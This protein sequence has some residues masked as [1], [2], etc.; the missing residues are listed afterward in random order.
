[1]HYSYISFS[2]FALFQVEDEDELEVHEMRKLFPDYAARFH[3]KEDSDDDEMVVE[4]TA[5]DNGDALQ[6]SLSFLMKEQETAS[7]VQ[8]NTTGLQMMLQRKE[9]L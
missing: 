8:E 5:N 9:H 3:H 1:M 2:V 4:N 7:K 6:D